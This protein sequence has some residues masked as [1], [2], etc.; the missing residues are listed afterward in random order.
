MVL[1]LLMGAIIASW[2]LSQLT[3][4]VISEKNKTSKEAKSDYEDMIDRRD[5]IEGVTNAVKQQY[6]AVSRAVTIHIENNQ[7]LRMNTQ[8]YIKG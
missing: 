4:G 5:T 1:F 7:E 8:G 3:A 2:Q 6:A